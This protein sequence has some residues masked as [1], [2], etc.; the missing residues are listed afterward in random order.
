MKAR[1]LILRLVCVA[2]TVTVVFAITAGASVASV[3]GTIK[4]PTGV[5]APGASVTVWGP[6]GTIY[7]TTNSQGKYYVPLDGTW[8]GTTY[9]EVKASAYTGWPPRLKCAAQYFVCDFPGCPPLTYG[10][11]VVNLTLW[12]NNCW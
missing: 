3:S 5:V 7:T 2:L 6:P 9:A 10:N 12:S 1:R 8:L 4:W 11:Y